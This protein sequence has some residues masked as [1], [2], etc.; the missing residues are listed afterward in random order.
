MYLESDSNCN[1]FR[2]HSFFL[3]GKR[4]KATGTKGSL[5]QGKILI[6]LTNLEA[7]KDQVLWPQK[8]ICS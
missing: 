6:I 8:R 5:N 1:Y 2:V 4:T 7:E 3:W